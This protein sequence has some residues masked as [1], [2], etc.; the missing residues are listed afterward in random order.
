MPFEMSEFGA[1]AIVLLVLVVVVLVMGVKSVPQGLEF[2][3]ER[4]LVFKGCR[5]HWVDAKGKRQGNGT[6]R[7]EG[8][9]LAPSALAWA[10]VT[11]SRLWVTDAGG[12]KKRELAVRQS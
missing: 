4:F 3:V 7:V 1:F 9:L 12:K 10:G 6:R 11:G 8:A 2:T 5:G